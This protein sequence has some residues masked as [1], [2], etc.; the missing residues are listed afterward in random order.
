MLEVYIFSGSYVV[1]YLDQVVIPFYSGDINILHKILYYKN[2]VAAKAK[3]PAELTFTSI[4]FFDCVKDETK[5][6]VPTK[7][8]LKDINR[9]LLFLVPY[10]DYDT[11]EEY[12]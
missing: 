5:F 11:G 8:H 4:N 12:K 1:S 6:N 3:L 2:T 7:I 9:R 10:H